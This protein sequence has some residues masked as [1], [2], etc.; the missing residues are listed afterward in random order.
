MSK[1]LVTFYN[2]HSH[3]KAVQILTEKLGSSVTYINKNQYVLSDEQIKMLDKN[4]IPYK[5]LKGDL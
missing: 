1:K 5:I 2:W 4:V 3:R